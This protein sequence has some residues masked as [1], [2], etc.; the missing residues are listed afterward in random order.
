M[1]A[2]F[3]SLNSRLSVLESSTKVRVDPVPNTWLDSGKELYVDE[4]SRIKP[5]EASKLEE[6]LL[7]LGGGATGTFANSVDKQSSGSK[8]SSFSPTSFSGVYNVKD[9]QIFNS[10]LGR[11]VPTFQLY[12]HPLGPEEWHQWQK[13][14]VLP[15]QVPVTNYEVNSPTLTK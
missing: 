5:Q 12:L 11:L 9:Y 2:E 14:N 15:K 4:L 8:F 10:T 1:K 3:S 13:D 6:S 7:G